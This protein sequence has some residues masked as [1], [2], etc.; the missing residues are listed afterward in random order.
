M[1]VTCP[2]SRTTRTVFSRSSPVSTSFSLLV[3]F[4][5]LLTPAFALALLA[6]LLGLAGLFLPVVM[7]SV[8]LL[9]TTLASALACAGFIVVIVNYFYAR[10]H[11]NNVDHHVHLGKGF[12]FAV[13]ATAA[14]L[15]ASWFMGLGVCCGAMRRRKQRTAETSYN[16]LYT[17]SMGNERVEEPIVMDSVHNDVVP[18]PTAYEE[19]VATYA[20]PRASASEPYRY[21]VER[22]TVTESTVIPMEDTTRA[23]DLSY[24]RS[25]QRSPVVVPASTNEWQTTTNQPRRSFGH[26]AE[27]GSVY[28]DAGAAAS[29]SHAGVAPALAYQTGAKIGAYDAAPALP[30][31]LLGTRGQTSSTNNTSDAWFLPNSSESRTTGLPNYKGTS[32]EYPTEKGRSVL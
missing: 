31:N 32:S 4:F 27:G 17:P 24:T 9:A 29:E 3:R 25:Q 18:V 7:N 10:H 22:E 14:L 15:F 12:W 23:T 1:S 6:V 11:F 13:A 8:A 2:T 16:G 21:P 30:G 28:E 20:E 5:L 26:S 19:P